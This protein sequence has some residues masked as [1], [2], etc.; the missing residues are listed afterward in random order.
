MD[1]EVRAPCFSPTVRN[2]ARAVSLGRIW[3]DTAISEARVVFSSVS[4]VSRKIDV[5]NSAI[6][7]VRSVMMN[8]RLIPRESP[9]K[10]ELQAPTDQKLSFSARIIECI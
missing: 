4:T 6:T 9:A 2:L 7:Q 5:E 10:C 3:A 1:S 8:K